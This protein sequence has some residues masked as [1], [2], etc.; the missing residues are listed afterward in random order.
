M[1]SPDKPN[2]I[3]SMQSATRCIV[4]AYLRELSDDKTEYGSGPS[5]ALPLTLKTG[6]S[7]CAACF[8]GDLAIWFKQPLLLFVAWGSV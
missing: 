1:H 6:L 5:V 2:H 7:R 4:L 8:R 3:F